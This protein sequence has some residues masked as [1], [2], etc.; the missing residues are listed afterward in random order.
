MLFLHTHTLTQILGSLL[1][2]RRPAGI[3]PRRVQPHTL[4]HLTEGPIA[5]LLLGVEDAGGASHILGES[6]YS[7][8]QRHHPPEHSCWTYNNLQT[9]IGASQPGGGLSAEEIGGHLTDTSGGGEVKIPLNLATSSTGCGVCREVLRSSPPTLSLSPELPLL[10]LP[11]WSPP[12]QVALS[13]RPSV[14][15]GRKGRAL[16]HPRVGQATERGQGSGGTEWGKVKEE[17]GRKRWWP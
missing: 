9:D 17:E 4:L 14:S 1:G 5:S 10:A 11:I 13:S 15:Q 16:G 2:W 8:G 3:L 7:A 6:G 12:P